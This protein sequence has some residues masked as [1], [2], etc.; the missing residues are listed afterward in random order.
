M[1]I[2]RPNLLGNTTTSGSI[3]PD[4][5]DLYDLGSPTKQFKDLYLSSAS[6]Y[7]DGTKIISSTTDVL[8]FTTDTGQSLKFL[9]A[10]VDDITLQTENGNIELKGTVEVTSGKKIIDSAGT[11]IQF[12]DSLGITGSIELTGTVDGIDIAGFNTEYTSFSASVAAGGV[13][14]YSQSFSAV[15]AVTAS[16]NLNTKNVTVSVYD[17]ADYLF[18]PVSIKT[19]DANNVYVQFATS[20][21]GRV[22]ITQ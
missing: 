17:N 2:H 14:S 20:R 22:V 1:N 21:T 6:L 8:T 13:G 5:T 16:H 4:A 7:I 9:E 15:T 18:S 10:G 12:G 3:I 11:I 19:H